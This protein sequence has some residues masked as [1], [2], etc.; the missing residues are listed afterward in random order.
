MAQT[1]HSCPEDLKSGTLSSL[2]KNLLVSQ[3]QGSWQRWHNVLHLQCSIHGG[4]NIKTKILKNTPNQNQEFVFALQVEIQRAKCK[5]MTTRLQQEWNFFT[6]TFII[7]AA[8]P[9]QTQEKKYLVSGQQGRSRIL[10]S[11]ALWTPIDFTKNTGHTERAA[12][13]SRDVRC[14]SR[15]RTRSG[16]ILEYS[17]SWKVEITGVLFYFSSAVTVYSQAIIAIPKK[18]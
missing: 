18:K 15:N 9:F 13:Q 16:A 8:C 17:R 12:Y 11:H 14:R 7:T 5:T 6:I 4:L 3:P 2:N 1:P 10:Q